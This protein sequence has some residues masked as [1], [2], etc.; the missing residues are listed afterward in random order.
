MAICV[1]FANGQIFY[2][3]EQIHL[4]Y[5]SNPTSMVVTWVTQS[6]VNTSLCRYGT[7]DLGMT[8]KGWETVFTDGGTEQRAIFIHRVVLSNLSPGKQ[9]MYRVGSNW[10]W[11]DKYT[12]TAM[13][14]GTD[15]SPTFAVYGDMGNKNGQSVG[16]LQEL[17]QDG[18]FDAVL[19]VGDFAYDMDTD[20][21]RIGDAFMNQLQEIAAYV[22]YMTAVGNHEQAYNFSNYKNR[23]TMPGGDQNGLFY[24]IDIG[25]VHFIMFSSEFY[26]F[27]QYGW[28]QI[29]EQYRWLEQDLANA[30]KAENRAKRPWII[31]MCHRPL[32]CSNNNDDEHC[33][34]IDNIIRVGLP[35]MRAYGIEDLLYKYGVDVHFQAHEH[36]YERM[37]P[38]YNLTV[39]N[40]TNND[41]YRNPRATVH[42]VTGS[43][44]CQEGVDPF[45]P[46]PHPWSAFHSDDYGFTLM[47]VFN[48]T[49]LYMEQIS[50]DKDG[51]V[52]DSFML[53]KEK[54][55]AGLFDCHVDGQM[56]GPM[57]EGF[58]SVNKINN[59][60]H[61][62]IPRHNMI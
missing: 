5:G 8:E 34:N 31:S 35:L 36:S 38:V 13:K 45:E 39:C 57:M 62:H 1:T 37:W 41:P 19:H 17:A 32:Y 4:S 18:Q 28:T 33:P 25:P 48:E 9:Y 60:I 29:A 51:Q 21:A 23:F 50:D 6:Q 49:H 42:I 22:P 55:G 59:K 24:S 7:S 16:R 27:P 43:A 44:G 47:K 3:P 53:N 46:I 56:Y 61:N 10:G 2:Q 20:N 14:S 52:I 54:H 15:W 11:S 26:Y 40:G 58:N 12:F 30:N